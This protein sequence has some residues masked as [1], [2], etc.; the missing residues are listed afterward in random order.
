[1][2]TSAEATGNRS[3]RIVIADDQEVVRIGWSTILQSAGFTIVATVGDGNALIAAIADHKPDVAVV[4][5]RMPVLDGLS[6]VEQLSL[7][8]HVEPNHSDHQGSTCRVIMVTTFDHDEYVDRALRAGAVGFLLKTATAAEL[9]GA[10]DNAL[11]GERTLAASAAT[12]LID[13]YLN[14]SV[15]YQ[16]DILDPLTARERDVLEL[17]GYGLSNHDICAQ[18]RVA[19]NTVKTHISRL[20]SKLGARD[21]SQLVI[22]AHR[23]GVLRSNHRHPEGWQPTPPLR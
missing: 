4:D 9:I 10:V 20:L 3:P 1:M 14:G 2:T 18:L 6:A 8:R 11:H 5:V 7:T 15:T 16:E 22:A 23:S 21:R 19:P 13:K 12:R 17:V